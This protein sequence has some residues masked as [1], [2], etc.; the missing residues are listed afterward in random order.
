M[1]KPGE[2]IR[3]ELL[4]ELYY[5]RGLSVHDVS[6]EL[7]VSHHKV[8]YWMD[9]Y[10]MQ[11][12]HWSDASYLKHNPGGEKFRIDLSHRELFLVGV[13]LYLGEGDKTN[14][15]LILTNS[16]PRILKLWIRFL[17]KVCN[18]SSQRLKARIDY[19]ED[20]DYQMLLAFWSGELGMSS[21]NFDRPT[22]KKGRA[23][24]GN[25]LGRRSLYG[26]VHVAFH[27]SRLKSLMVSWMNDLLEGKL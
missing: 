14:P 16:D 23:A 22:L 10:G 15:S 8:V 27:D 5:G 24:R 3:A 18:V 19:Y 9:Q 11:R 26:T 7:S 12:R 25:H 21:E 13:A 1:L 4:E 20:L 2:P 6:E 17:D